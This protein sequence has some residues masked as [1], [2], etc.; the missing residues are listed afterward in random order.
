[1]IKFLRVGINVKK[2]K[3]KRMK[4]KKIA[5]AAFLICSAIHC[6]LQTNV[7][8]IEITFPN[9]GGL[10]SAKGDLFDDLTVNNGT[11]EMTLGDVK[12]G[13]NNNEGGTVIVDK[14][15][16]VTIEEGKELLNE[17][18]TLRLKKN[19]KIKKRKKRD[20]YENN[21]RNQAIKRNIR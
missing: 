18:G 11:G 7:N 15:K 10:V 21:I 14:N 12:A 8:A 1:M 6:N 5:I 3:G 4:K 2:K 19:S 16:T 20:F 13:V 9:G 17:N